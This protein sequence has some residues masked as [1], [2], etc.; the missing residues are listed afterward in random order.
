MAIYHYK[1]DKSLHKSV[2]RPEIKHSAYFNVTLHIF[3]MKFYDFYVIKNT[4]TLKELTQTQ[5]IA[6][7]VSFSL[8]SLSLS[9]TH[10]S[11]PGPEMTHQTYGSQLPYSLTYSDNLIGRDAF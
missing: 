11:E 5:N 9:V 6:V 3:Y 2:P 7:F 10:L 4:R 1:Y 8:F